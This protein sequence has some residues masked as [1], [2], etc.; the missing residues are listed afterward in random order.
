M[1]QA[2]VDNQEHLTKSNYP[3][4]LVY[5]LSGFYNYQKIPQNIL[6]NLTKLYPLFYLTSN[7]SVYL[8]PTIVM[9]IYAI[10]IMTSYASRT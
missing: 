9:A 5:N 1:N 10:I 6:F 7:P 2:T 4:N 8:E 3:N